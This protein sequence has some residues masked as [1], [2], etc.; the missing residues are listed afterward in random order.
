[1]KSAALATT[2]VSE[3]EGPDVAVSPGS[4]LTP[5]SDILPHTQTS[6]TNFSTKLQSLVPRKF[7]ILSFLR[8]RE[9]GSGSSSASA[10][11]SR[12]QL[13]NSEGQSFN[14]VSLIQIRQKIR[15][16]LR[17]LFIYPLAYMAMWI[18]PFVSHVLQYDEYFAASPPFILSAFVT[19]VLTSQ[20]AVDCWIFNARERP[21][22]HLNMTEKKGML[23]QGLDILRDL[24]SG[25]RTSSQIW[26]SVGKSRAAMTAEATLAYRRR[27]EEV[28]ARASEMSSTGR[29]EGRE[30]SWWDGQDATGERTSAD[31]EW[32]VFP[33]YRQEGEAYEMGLQS[34]IEPQ[35]KKH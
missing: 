14:Q 10:S 30:R 16:Q 19:I 1:M 24:T 7:S 15:Q 12:L 20:S 11:M 27:D 6:F 22:E 13:V 26:G 5:V 28:A 33:L 25:R 4:T 21:W 8:L 3:L 18:L 2:S 9:A 34:K 29:N 32:A 35:R 31:A 23:G 17:F